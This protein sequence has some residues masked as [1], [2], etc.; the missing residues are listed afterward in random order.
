MKSTRNMW[1][2]LAGV[3]V[4]ELAA[5]IGTIG[6]LQFLSE[7]LSSRFLQSIILVSGAVFGIFLAPY[8]G[9]IIDQF[10]PKPILIYSGLLRI[11]AIGS[12]LFAIWNANVWLMIIFQLIIVISSSFYFPTVNAVMPTVV[13]ERH[14][15]KANMLN[16]NLATFA[17]IFGTALGGV[18]LTFVS[19]E[20]LYI[21]S[22][23]TYSILI[24]LTLMLTMDKTELDT[25][26]GKTRLKQSFSE[27]FPL[28]RKEPIVCTLLMLTCIPFLF[29]GG[30]N[31]FAIELS[32]AQNFDSLKGIIYAVEGSS[33]LLA[34][35]FMRKI[36][37]KWGK[38]NVLFLGSTMVI[39]SMLLL[40]LPIMSVQIAAFAIF[41][42]ASGIF[43][44]LSNMEAQVHIS[45]E[46]LGRFFSFKRMIE[47]TVIQCSLIFSGL[48]LDLASFQVL[49]GLYAA[50]SIVCV[51]YAW[52]FFVKARPNVRNS[53]TENI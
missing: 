24:V 40:L 49:M 36:T 6:S 34:G 12:M 14:L 38:S 26:S 8:A 53:S 2:L 37:A 45:K 52:R 42:F 35:V 9:K 10:S 3:F 15:M 7:T 22:G 21:L 5:W 30:F 20:K 47:T 23:L 28:I 50:L 16:F 19:L 17:R 25:K 27:I 48:L 31:L 18:L 1:L 32:E 51:A 39:G 33:I 44:P 13:P 41:G 11:A 46:A 43:I 4:S 29:I